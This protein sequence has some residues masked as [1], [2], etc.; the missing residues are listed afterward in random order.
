MFN[1]DISFKRVKDSQFRSVQLAEFFKILG[2]PKPLLAG[3]KSVPRI[4]FKCTNKEIANFIQGYFDG[5][6]GIARSYKRNSHY[7]HVTSKSQKLINDIQN[8]LLRLGAISFKSKFLGKSQDWKEKRKYYK[9]CIYGVELIHLFKNIKLKKYDTK[10]LKKIAKSKTDTNWD[11]IPL[12]PILFKRVREGLNLARK[13]VNK[14]FQ[15]LASFEAGRRGVS[16]NLFKKYLGVLIKNDK[17]SVYKEEI[18]RRTIKEEGI[19]MLADEDPRG[20]PWSKR[21]S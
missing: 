19:H 1:L 21:K 8:L 4:L 17:N 7:L 10:L 6:A 14:E 20:V 12:S 2:L 11:T 9:L 3:N 16:R 13:D 5:D 18:V 15:T